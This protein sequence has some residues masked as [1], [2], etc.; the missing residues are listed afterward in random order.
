M[1]AMRKNILLLL[2]ATAFTGAALSPAHAAL[3]KTNVARQC[4]TALASLTVSEDFD[5]LPKD[6]ALKT[7]L[8]LRLAPE[9]TQECSSLMASFEQQM[10][11][12]PQV[13]AALKAQGVEV[14]EFH[15]L[16]ALAKG[17]LASIT[18]LAVNYLVS[19]QNTSEIVA[20]LL[21]GTVER[22]NTEKGVT[23]VSKVASVGVGAETAIDLLAQYFVVNKMFGWNPNSLRYL[24][25]QVPSRYATFTHQLVGVLPAS[26][27][28]G[29][30]GRFA[31]TNVQQAQ[32]AQYIAFF[33][34]LVVDKI[35][36]NKYVDWMRAKSLAE[37]AELEKTLPAATVNDV[38]ALIS[39]N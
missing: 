6:A 5:V 24:N 34:S 7:A 36:M 29:L 39:G 31:K 9:Q 38:N 3:N 10:K 20:E 8:Y 4:Y 27:I 28:S 1:L 21:P 16:P 35:I 33:A 17:T 2:L 32:M 12:R 26:I 23:T 37:L 22:T 30:A 15:F 13:L 19:G 18:K 14:S 25:S 11:F